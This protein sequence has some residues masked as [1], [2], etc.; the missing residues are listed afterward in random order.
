MRNI[1][2][3]CLAFI[4]G[5]CLAS[6]ALGQP[7]AWS[8]WRHGAQGH[9]QALSSAERAMEPMVVYFH[10]DWCPWCRK[11]N[12]RYLRHGQVRDVLSGM[13]KVEI[14]PEQNSAGKALFGKYG[15]KGYPSFYVQ[16]PGS[17]EPTMKISP[18][19]RSG[20]QSLAEIQSLGASP[21]ASQ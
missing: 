20:E 19:K 2:R 9:T 10:T 1:Y 15:G 12:E 18:F 16:I 5:A 7:S 3:Y 4:L 21:G 17:G 8:D 14:N 11:L 13:Q 6:P